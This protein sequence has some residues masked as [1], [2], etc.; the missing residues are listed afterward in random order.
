MALHTKRF[1]L[2]LG[3]LLLILSLSACGGKKEK[4][5]KEILADIKLEDYYLSGDYGLE[6]KSHTIDKR[7]TNAEDK[8]DYVWFSLTASNN[9]FEYYAGYEMMYVLYNDGWRLEDIDIFDQG[10]E[11]SDYDSISQDNAD[12]IVAE[13]GYDDYD[14]LYR[15]NRYNQVDFYYTASTL[16][17]YL[18]TDYSI[19]VSYTFRPEFGW[20]TPKVEEDVSD[21]HLELVGTWKS[22]EYD[23]DLTINVLSVEKTGSH[24]YDMTFTCEFINA[25]ID[26]GSWRHTEERNTFVQDTP[27]TVNIHEE[28][29]TWNGEILTKYRVDDFALTASDGRSH[30]FDL[31]VFAGKEEGG[32]TAWSSQMMGYGYGIAWCE[33]QPV[34]FEPIQEI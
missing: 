26:V 8:T 1:F 15:E 20:G 33:W 18:K 7:Q 27:I 2:L 3:V 11:V 19:R 12:L 23:M 25:D 14:Y 4:S 24:D 21:Y 22:S 10:Y 28:I 34:F 31:Y 16:L 9:E 17:N 13:G 6:V 29:S 5:E 32:L 30:T